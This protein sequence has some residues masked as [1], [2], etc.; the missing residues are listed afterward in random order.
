MSSHFILFA[1]ITLLTIVSI[2]M[3]IINGTTTLTKMENVISNVGRSYEEIGTCKDE[4]IKELLA[5]VSDY[6]S[7]QIELAAKITIIR[8]LETRIC[9]NTRETEHMQEN[10]TKRG[11]EMDV[12]A[13][14]IQLKDEEIAKYTTEINQLEDSN[15]SLQRTNVIMERKLESVKKNLGT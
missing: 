12:L 8:H 1:M 9:D 7:I 14:G 2:V 3:W 13:Q 10:F 6:E 15:R 4:K 5:I 11:R